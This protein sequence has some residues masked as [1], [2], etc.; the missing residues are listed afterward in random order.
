MHPGTISDRQNE[1]NR[2][3]QNLD[4]SDFEWLSGQNGTWLDHFPGRYIH[5]IFFLGSLKHVHFPRIFFRGR[6]RWRAAHPDLQT[7]KQTLY[8]YLYVLLVKHMLFLRSRMSFFRGCVLF[9][10]RLSDLLSNEKRLRRDD[11]MK[12]LCS[13]FSGVDHMPFFLN[14]RIIDT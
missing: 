6:F 2:Q 10:Y 11:F 4:F 13:S 1:P 7:A 5:K 3:F 12:L 14:E 9:P 8:I